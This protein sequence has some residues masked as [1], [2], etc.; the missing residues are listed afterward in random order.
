VTITNAALNAT[1]GRILKL[2]G[3]VA[4][5]NTGD[6]YGAFE[7]DI[8]SSGT[9]AGTSAA[10]STWLNFAAG[11]VPGGNI[12]AV[13]N[14]GIYLPSGITASSAKMIIGARMQYIADDGANPGELY[15]FSTNIYSNVLTAIFDVNAI[16]DLGGSTSAQTGNDYKVPLF[17]DATAGQLWYVNVYHS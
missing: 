5:P 14:N 12:I 1:A 8:T 3:T 17:R 4:A 16:A 6:G 10:S 11:S 9:V 13:Q 7:V 15:C 2:A